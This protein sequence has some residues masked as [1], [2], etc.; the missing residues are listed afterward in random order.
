MTRSHTD[1]RTKHAERI[2]TLTDD[3]LATYEPHQVMQ[4]AIYHGV[5]SR[6]GEWLDK[7]SNTIGSWAQQ[8]T[9]SAQAESKIDPYGRN[10]PLAYFY[11]FF[12]T[13]LG[14][15]PEGAGL[16]L[17]WLTIKY[18]EERAAQ[19]RPELLTALNANEEI[20]ELAQRILE[21]TGTVN[22]SV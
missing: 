20:A 3:E 6:I 12:L 8:P 18:A 2:K 1:P 14:C 22:G 10:G 7:H 4:A 15:T 21:L 9:A 19:G 17:R 16:M 11:G 13:V 5:A